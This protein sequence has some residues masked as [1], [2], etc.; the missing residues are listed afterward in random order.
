[1]WTPLKA[2]VLIGSGRVY[3]TKWLYDYIAPLAWVDLISCLLMTFLNCIGI[4]FELFTYDGSANR[5]CLIIPFTFR[6]CIKHCIF[7]IWNGKITWAN[8]LASVNADGVF[9][10]FQCQSFLLSLLVWNK[11]FILFLLHLLLL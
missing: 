1:M 6:A 4:V 8:L 3:S 11:I 7:W 2:Q 9:F 5:A 10:I